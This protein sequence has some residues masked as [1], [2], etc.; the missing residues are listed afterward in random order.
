M[1]AIQQN[2]A[3]AKTPGRYRAAKNALA[4]ALLVFIVL[5]IFYTIDGIAP[6]GSGT[7]TLACMDADIQY[8]DFFA[9]LQ[10][11]SSGE[12]SLLYSFA[13][14]LGGTPIAVFSYYLSSPFN[15]LFLLVSNNATHIAFNIVVMLKLMTAAVTASIFLNKRFAKLESPIAVALAISYALMQYSFA[16][17]SNIMWLDG[18]YMLPLMALAASGLVKRGPGIAPLATAAGLSI[19]FNWYSGA[20]N[21]LFIIIWFFFEL[22]LHRPLES[23]MPASRYILGRG[24]R[25]AG[26]M[27]LGIGISLVFFLPT[28]FSLLQGRAEGGFGSFDLNAL[29]GNPL[30]I[31]YGAVIGSK[32]TPSSATLYCGSVVLLGCLAMPF[33]RSLPKRSRIAMAAL[34][35]ILVLALYWQPLFVLFSLFI[36]AN[37]YYFRYAYVCV[38]GLVAISATYYESAKESTPRFANSR[39]ASSYATIVPVA[40]GT[41]MVLTAI[42]TLR[43]YSTWP[44]LAATCFALILASIALWLSG[45]PT[46]KTHTPQG[47]AKAALPLMLFVL[48]VE[49]GTNAHLMVDSYTTDRVQQRSEYVSEQ[50]AQIDDIRQQDP[51]AYRITQDTTD[52]MK[53]NGLTANYNEGLAF[54]YP[55]I[56]SYT[57]AP[58]NKQRAFLDAIGYRIC[59][60]NMN[61]VN[62]SL[63]S[64]DSLL[65]VRYGLLEEPIPGYEPT[66]DIEQA[67][68]KTAYFNPFSLPLAFSVSSEIPFEL[69]NGNGNPFEYQNELFSALM[70]QRVNLYRPVEFSSSSQSDADGE[71][72]T[73]YTLDAP[74]GN[75]ALYGNLILSNP[76][77]PSTL[78]IAGKETGYSQWLS[79][80]VFHIS[81]EDPAVTISFDISN[82]VQET[83]FYYLDL[84]LLANVTDELKTSGAKVE[85]G[86]AEALITIDCSQGGQ[87]LLTSI[88]FDEGWTITVNGNAADSSPAFG[89][90]TAIPLEKGEN[91]IE[92]HF[93]PRGLV[94]GAA[95]SAA[96]LMVLLAIF[97]IP[98]RCRT[99][100]KQDDN[101]RKKPTR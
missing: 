19:L 18:V 36:P 15:V 78:T 74:G 5:C 44:E 49:L 47:V 73:T 43:P 100:R 61:I 2:E 46:E 89:C 4:S 32:S 26:A 92:M 70:G 7:R 14:G 81:E 93:M 101:A 77:S 53:E 29:N 80:S 59:G 10:N 76:D 88:P 72:V 50:E 25:F 95:G 8:N 48:C 60:P 31:I 12:D 94:L 55:T 9:W 75:I 90:L 40:I 54:N 41:C 82:K 57:S 85:T 33:Q 16:Q 62:T 99:L 67:N 35:L 91:I 22:F 20:I 51:G 17:A 24:L 86:K 68:G 58:D 96:S 6:F 69:P 1:D 84:D 34:A 83:Q 42:T 56:A 45:S 28:V 23:G 3:A 38:F 63:L 21:C 11:V 71:T 65:G 79:P 30:N 64:S 27:L 52:K 87:T 37:S 13:K 66:A 97:A 98:F 39:F